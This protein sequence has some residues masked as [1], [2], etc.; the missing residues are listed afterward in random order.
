MERI[1]LLFSC[2]IAGEHNCLL[3]TKKE[4]ALQRTASFYLVILVVCA[5]ESL[6]GTAFQKKGP[7]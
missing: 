4:A 6:T 3:Y 2:F 1:S 5:C 7:P